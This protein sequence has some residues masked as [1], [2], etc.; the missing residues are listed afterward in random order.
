M[1]TTI[2]E[3][4]WKITGDDSGIKTSLAQS[5]KMAKKTGGTFSK[6]ALGI[7]AAFAAIGF[8]R[9]TKGLIKLASDAEET[10]QKFGVVFSTVADKA[11]EAA[12][13]LAQNFGLSSTASKQ[14]LSDTGDLLTGF[15]FT[16][17]SALDLSTQLNELAVDLASFT[18]Y[19]GGAEGASTALTKALLG[20]RESIKSLG[21]AISE[22]DLKAFI[23]SQGKSYEM[24]TKQEK[25]QATLT[26]AIAQSKN[27]LGDFARSQDSVA[28]IQRRVNARFNDLGTE[29]GKN[30]LP[31]VGNLGLAFLEASKDGG[32]I[33]KLFDAM[34]KYIAEVINGYAKLIAIINQKSV[35]GEQQKLNEQAK[36]YLNIAKITNSEIIK[37]YGSLQKAQ[38][39]AKGDS[40]RAREANNFL[41]VR[42]N[43]LEKTKSLLNQASDAQERNRSAI[44]MIEKIE[45]RIKGV[46]EEITDRMQDRKNIAVDISKLSKQVKKDQEDLS[47]N[48]ATWATSLGDVIN[49]WDKLVQLGDKMHAVNTVIQSTGSEI[50]NILNAIGQL[51]QAQTNARLAQIDAQLQAELEAAGVADETTLEQ[52]QREYDIAQAS[53]SDLEKEEKRRALVKAQIENKYQKERAMVQYEGDLQAWELQKK[54]A[55]AQ[56]ALAII[57]AYASAAAIPFTGFILA[58]IAAAVAAT[59]A[60]IQYQAVSAAKPQP[61]KFAEG[62]IVPGTNFSGDNV[63][64]RANSGE[65][66]LNN[67]QQSRLLNMANGGG[68]A[69]GGGNITIYLGDELI[70]DNLYKASKSGNLIIDTRAVVS[71]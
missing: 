64:I 32:V 7:T 12:Q 56:G 16:Q 26:L 13:S 8:T 11:N 69:S 40:D 10:S 70:Y 71:R 18:N 19:S 20:E 68:G 27:A 46:N 57:N 62:G 21:I 52:A 22:A 61:P 67:A 5:E 23:E 17:E 50:I 65:L 34:S 37:R 36:E 30:L 33:L 14:L 31:A 55:L 9:L 29:I 41:I 66:I 45:N 59:A 24:A 48:T 53:G 28:N 63:P 35:S 2:G 58:P 15:G 6:I 47:I 42:N 1:A 39:L 51:Q 44:V 4:V 49:K 25:A 38:E 3:L 54:L 43:A 60:A